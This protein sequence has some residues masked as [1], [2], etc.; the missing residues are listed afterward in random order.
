MSS[1]RNQIVKVIDFAESSSGEVENLTTSS[2]PL[3]VS[4]S[5]DAREAEKTGQEVAAFPPKV[6]GALR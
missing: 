1:G 3:G 4:V 2:L 5:V 6:R